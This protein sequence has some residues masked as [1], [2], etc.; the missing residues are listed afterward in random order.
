MTKGGT[1]PLLS[2][3]ENCDHH[4][5]P[6]NELELNRAFTRKMNHLLYVMKVLQRFKSLIAER[7]AAQGRTVSAPQ[8]LTRGNAETAT[9]D[10]DPAVEK[11]K[12]EEIE[13]LL[14]QRRRVRSQTGD[15]SAETDETVHAPEASDQEPLFLGIGTGA[16]DDFAMDEATPNVVADSP[17]AVDF[18][19]YDRAYEDAVEEKL[20]SKP[21]S[22]PTLYL[23]R[24]VKDKGRLKHL[25]ALIDESGLSPASAGGK[26]AELASKMGLAD[27]PE[28][29]EPSPGAGGP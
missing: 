15:N 5:E 10:F 17:T 27:T 18:N 6:P 22:K 23:T 19:V 24:F 28:P 9:A 3:E 14:A 7:R 16:R 1:D 21:T 12:A 4:I 26:L 2:A 13:A 25:E 11:A 29:A 8:V 20:R